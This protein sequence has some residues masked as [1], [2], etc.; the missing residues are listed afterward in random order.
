MDQDTKFWDK[1]AAKY[2]R[3][4]VRNQAAYGETLDRTRHYLTPDQNVLEIGCGTGSTALLLA[5]SVGHITATDLSPAMIAIAQDK[6]AD[7]NHPN[8]RFQAARL[9][10]DSLAGQAFDAVLAFNV[11]H[12]VRDIPAEI[13]AI[14]RLLK[15]GGFFISKTGCIGEAGRFLAILIAVMRKLGFAPFVNSLRY[16][17]LDAM[18]ACEGFEIIETGLYPASDH[19]R[20][21]VARKL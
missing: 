7:G 8:V 20:F 3:K 14:H 12:L 2:A 13:R 6:L 16:G 10:D 11:L 4:P 15:P 1:A 9:S 5:P 18:I 17:E 19:A 21:V